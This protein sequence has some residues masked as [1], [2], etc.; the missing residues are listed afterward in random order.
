MTEEGYRQRERQDLGC[1]TLL[2]SMLELSVQVPRLRSELV[3][4]NPKE[5]G[6]VKLQG[7][8]PKCYSRRGPGRWERLMIKRALGAVISGAYICP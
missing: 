6:F 7:S 8:L 3:N 4:T 1:L 5:Q 2:E